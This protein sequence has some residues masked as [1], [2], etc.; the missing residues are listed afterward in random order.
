MT[1]QVSSRKLSVDAPNSYVANF[2]CYLRPI[3]PTLDFMLLRIRNT[4]ME[5]RLIQQKV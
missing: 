4:R 1:Y 3:H 5:Q 2:P